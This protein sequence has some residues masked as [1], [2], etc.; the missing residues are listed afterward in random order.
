MPPRRLKAAGKL[1]DAVVVLAG[2]A[3]GRDAY[4]QALQAQV[5]Q[6][7]L[8]RQRPLRRPC[9]GHRRG[10]PG[11]ARGGRR[12]H[13]ARGLRPGGHRGGG[14]GLPGDR[15]RHRRPAGDGAGRA[16]RGAGRHHG[17]AGAA[18]RCRGPGRAAG[19][20]AGAR[21][22]PSGRPWAGGPGRTCWPNSRWKPCSAARWRSTTGCWAPSLNGVSSKP[23]LP[24]IPWMRPPATTLTC[25][26][27]SPILVPALI[28]GD[29]SVSTAVVPQRPCNN[30]WR[31]QHTS[32]NES[33]A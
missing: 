1:G 4:V 23:R 31:L 15:H 25:A 10:L 11:R 9:R 22:R 30:R 13:R 16:G 14:H 8:E 5:A 21:R 33:R 12:L 20:G 2:D 27:I 24:G 3:Q 19:R 32:S 26:I 17:L 29:M 6:A 7:G 18:G 28:L